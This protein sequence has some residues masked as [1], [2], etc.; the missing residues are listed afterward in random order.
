MSRPG[1]LSRSG[2]MIPRPGRPTSLSSRP[3]RG[4]KHLRYVQL[5]YVP[6]RSGTLSERASGDRLCGGDG[7]GILRSEDCAGVHADDDKVPGRHVPRSNI[8]PV[9]R[10]E[11]GR[12]LTG[13]ATISSVT[14][15]APLRAR[16]AAVCSSSGF[17]S[18]PFPDSHVDWIMASGLLGQVACVALRIF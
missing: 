11:K 2:P 15:S 12:D 6:Y 3:R 5:R 4:R 14:S 8:G 13:T 7:V 9:A 16:R 18:W 1:L 10:R 17:S